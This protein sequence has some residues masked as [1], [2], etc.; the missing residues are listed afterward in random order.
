MD[1]SIERR[2]LD[3]IGES[4]WREQ[5]RNRMNEGMEE[6]RKQRNERTNEIKK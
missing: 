4:E 2:G 5:E 1:Y 3:W 6:G